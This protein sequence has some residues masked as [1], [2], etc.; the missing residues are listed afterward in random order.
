MSVNRE[1]ITR[2]FHSGEY[3]L[4]LRDTRQ[5]QPDV[6][7]EPTL[8]G[9]VAE[10]S[11][12]AGDVRRARDWAVACTGSQLPAVRARGQLVL[13]RCLR[14][15][16]EIS[17]ATDLLQAALRSAEEARDDELE[18]WTAVHLLRHLF[19]TQRSLAAAM[20][21]AARAKVSKAGSRHLTAFLHSTV[22]VGECQ[23]GRVGEGRRH[24]RTALQLLDGHPHPWLEC[25]TLITQA[26]VEITESHFAAA[27]TCLETLRTVAKN[28]GLEADY[29]RANVNI[30]NMG[31]LTGQ[32]DIASRALQEA[33]DSPHTHF[34]ARVAAADAL[35]RVRLAQ[36][37]LD[38]CEHLL[39]DIDR[40]V[41]E[42]SLTHVYV[43]QW[44][45]LTKGRVLLKRGDPRAALQALE[46]FDSLPD[47]V[48]DQPL[49]AATRLTKAHALA[50]CGQSIEGA[51]HLA[52]TLD[53]NPT[54]I[55]VLQG[56]Y[57]FSA[58]A[59]VS[60]SSRGLAYALRARARRLWA[61]QGTAS[62]EH[63]FPSVAEHSTR[64]SSSD[65][66]DMAVVVDSITSIL[67][68]GAKPQLLADELRETI[69][70]LGCSPDVLV[71]DSPDHRS[72]PGT[73]SLDLLIPRQHASPLRVRCA[74]PESP[75]QVVTLGSVIRV[76]ELAIELERLREADR[77]R[78]AL[79]P[80]ASAEAMAG[81]IFES[82]AM[83]EVLT[84]AR[85][86]ASAPVPVLITGETGTGKEVLARLIHNY[87]GR[88]KAPL[89]PFNCTSLSREMIES[90]LFGH[91]KG[92][93][94]GAT[95]HAPGV[96]RAANHG[97]LL[98]DEIGDMPLEVQPKLLRFLESGEI[99]PLGE[100]RPIKVDVRVIAATNVDL[101]GRV[102]SGAF[103]EDLYYRL[104]IVPLHLP[105][106]RERRSEIPALAS[107]YLA[108]FG[109]EFAKGDL[110][111]SED[112]V[113]Q[114]LLYRWPGNIRQLANEMRRIAAMAEVGAIVMPEHL[115]HEI[116]QAP[117][118][119]ASRREPQGNE[120]IVRL[121]QPIAAAVEH[122]ERAMIIT[123]L[124]KSNGLV[125]RAAQLLGLS[126]KGLYLKRQRYG[127]D[128]PV[129][130]EQVDVQ[131]AG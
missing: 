116:S 58:A 3:G 127:I 95:D 53:L 24:L 63:E 107:H 71:A 100:P 13:A 87:S 33:L 131:Q 106:L 79:W 65:S 27:A 119:R 50:M 68:L 2:L 41:D 90:Q 43:V 121:D 14:A 69:R 111:L 129:V 109:R 21:P 18:A 17:R 45:K 93:F 67:T 88:S 20:V 64:T 7:A 46:W 92:S 49:V 52:A 10:A 104:S 34:I 105:P 25:L 97:T 12:E 60:E 78:S 84:A 5:R 124:E 80:D 11:F 82:D 42:Q 73:R 19:V 85:R 15:T 123:A 55:S 51:R 47:G 108:Q 61:S 57:Y 75:Q 16:G 1:T 94:T 96:V 54:E 9:L 70:H 118:A 30:G 8:T 103:R 28:H 112:A 89:V 102:K 126:R 44:A 128:V 35:A 101:K 122:V 26:A 37:R 117:R 29:A 83:R 72:I 56:Y 38:D 74:I 86:V 6:K 91:R 62:L 76:G 66:D 40:A 125:E 39:R 130:N 81:V 99:H 98:L 36:D 110:R 48:M 113:E 115:S 31:M 59:T 32:H 4:I 120:F 77:Q 114:L 22:A 23:A